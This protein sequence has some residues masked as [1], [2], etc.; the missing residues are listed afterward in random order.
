[1]ANLAVTRQ[2]EVFITRGNDSPA[3]ARAIQRRAKDGE[4]TR[5]VEGVYLLE[6]D[7]E[8]QKAVVRRNWFRILGALAPGAVVSYR[9][10]YSGGITPDG[11]E[12]ELNARAFDE[13]NNSGL[14]GIVQKDSQAIAEKGVSR[15]V[16]AAGKAATRAI[17]Q[18]GGIAGAAVGE[19]A[20]SMIGDTD[21][22]MQ[23]QLNTNI[24]VY[25]SPQPLVLRVEKSF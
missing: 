21:Q 5:I 15:G 24:V 16:I 12:F 22:V 6:K 7:P 20:N 18:A 10:A 25:V 8:A 1:M 9:S 3:E 4:L 17:S 19:G 13:T 14:A 2:D 23:E 11:D